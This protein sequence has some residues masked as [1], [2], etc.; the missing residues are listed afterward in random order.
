M[1]GCGISNVG[2]MGGGSQM[3]QEQGLQAAQV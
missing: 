3:S 1:F 2:T